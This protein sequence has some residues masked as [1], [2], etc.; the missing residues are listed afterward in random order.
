MKQLKGIETRHGLI[1]YY[2]YNGIKLP[3]KLEFKSNPAASTLRNPRP[4]VILDNMY[5]FA[6]PGGGDF[7]SDRE[8]ED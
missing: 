8:K 6:L 7:I 3:V 4:P 1:E 5:V 2:N